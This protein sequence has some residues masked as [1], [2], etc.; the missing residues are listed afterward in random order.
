MPLNAMAKKNPRK[1]ARPEARTRALLGSADERQSRGRS[2]VSSVFDAARIAGYQVKYG[3]V[4]IMLSHASTGKIGGWN[5]NL[6]HWYLSQ[7]FAQGREGTPIAFGFEWK[8]HANGHC[9]WQLDGSHNAFAFVAAVE[10]L[11]GIPIGTVE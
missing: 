3:T 9:W 10:A 1:D 4:Q 7:V 5:T 8:T 2:D 11:T 6:G